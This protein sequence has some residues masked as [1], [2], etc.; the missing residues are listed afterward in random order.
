VVQV[1]EKSYQDLER[2]VWN[3]DLCSGCGA[4]IA[5]CPADALYFTNGSAPVNS[6]YCKAATDRVS[7]GACYAVC[8]RVQPVAPQGIGTY[9]EILAAQAAFPV[10]RRQSGGAITA[11]LTAALEEGV[12]DAV[13]TVTEDRW[14]KKTSSAVI[15]SGEVLVHQAGS[16]YMWWVPLLT[17]LKEAVITRKYRKIAI[18]GV[19][20]VMRAVRLLRESDHDLLRPFG[21]SIRFAIGLFCTESF[22]YAKLIEGKLK[23]EHGIEPWQVHRLDVKG[24]LEVTYG[25]GPALSIPLE[26]LKDC[27]RPGCRVCTD[28]TAI[29]ADIS[30]GSIGSPEG[31]TTLIARN[32]TGKELVDLAVRRGTLE[33]GGDVNTAIIERLAGQKARNLKH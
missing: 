24:R 7:C 1:S 27:V 8:P 20:C 13:V 22:D 26:E 33:V 32:E 17:S 2:E 5:V 18:V 29:D 28:L 25:D 14:T 4:C 16:R 30:A 12:I 10:E 31:S 21:K 9:L 6:G 3:Q 23:V 19:P 11:I 15:T